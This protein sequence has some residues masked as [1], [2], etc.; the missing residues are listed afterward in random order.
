MLADIAAAERL[1]TTNVVVDRLYSLGFSHSV[2]SQADGER[3]FHVFYYL[4]CGV[5]NETLTGIG[6]S[7]CVD[8]HYLR[9]GFKGVTKDS[10]I[11][12]GACCF[13][14]M[15]ICLHFFCWLFCSLSLSS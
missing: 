13:Q 8:Y 2:C 3:N 15:C 7:E 5:S 4:F 11:D 12:L 1:L 9:G 14:R 6:L 10:A